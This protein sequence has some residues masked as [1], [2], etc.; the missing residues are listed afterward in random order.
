MGTKRAFMIT[1]PR[2]EGAEEILQRLRE[3]EDSTAFDIESAA[4]IQKNLDG[5]VHVDD[6]DNVEA[7]E[8]SLAGAIAGT[9][10]GA[11]LGGIPGAIV[12][13]GAGALTGGVSAGAINLNM[14]LDQDQ[15]TNIG[16]SLQAGSSA[17][18]VVVEND[19]APVFERSVVDEFGDTVKHHYLDLRDEAIEE[20]NELKRDTRNALN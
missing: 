9:V 8:G 2:Y 19:R 14:D 4:I 1:S 11:L 17:L 10:L 5:D 7:D 20:W 16:E 12:G 18:V 3:I 13:A 6:Q 15:L